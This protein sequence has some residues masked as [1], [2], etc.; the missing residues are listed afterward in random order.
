MKTKSEVL[1]LIPALYNL[2]LNQFN[3]SFKVLRS[4]NGPEFNLFDF[5][6]NKGIIHQLSCMDTPQQNSIVERKHQHLLNVARAIRFQ[7]NVPLNLW[8]DCVLTAT[9]LIN[10]LPSPLL[11]NKTPF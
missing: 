2:V 6:T 3:N 9:Y 7:S 4:D 5:Y 1:S 8:G 11:K 10:R